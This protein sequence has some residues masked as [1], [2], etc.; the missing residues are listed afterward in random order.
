M[1]IKLLKK[2]EFNLNA[3]NSYVKDKIAG[4]IMKKVTLIPFLQPVFNEDNLV[5]GVEVLLR[6]K[7]RNIYNSLGDIILDL[8]GSNNIDLITC[9]LIREVKL[10]FINLQNMLPHG[11]EFSFNVLAAQLNNKDVVN[12]I[13]DFNDSF[14]MDIS[15]NI[16][17]VEREFICLEDSVA[18]N[19]KKMKELGVK[20][21]LDDFGSGS[22]S[23]IYINKGIFDVVKLDKSLTI[24]K[25]NCLVYGRLIYS[26]T[27]AIHNLCH[28]NRV[29][30]LAE[31]VENEKQLYLLKKLNIQLF[32]GYLLARPM[33]LSD[34]IFYYLVCN[35][36]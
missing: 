27:Q 20:F 2:I 14:N 17:I 26:I 5:V 11:F 32:Q 30:I 12:A 21:S 34:F 23:M 8:E 24:T 18:L 6:E 16:E 22:S 35:E 3:L 19:I 33:S 36:R 10:K 29:K 1:K 28:E 25:D 13:C 7:K 4:A 31:G 15:I 9:N